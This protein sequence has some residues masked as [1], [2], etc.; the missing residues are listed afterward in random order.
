MGLQFLTTGNSNVSVGAMLGFITTGSNNIGVGAGSNYITSESNNINIGTN[1]ASTVGESNRIR[2]GDSS[3][4]NLY[5]GNRAI[6]LVLCQQLQALQILH[7]G[8]RCLQH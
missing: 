4:D 2:I 5:I 6:R 1:I 7:S 3:H 8:L